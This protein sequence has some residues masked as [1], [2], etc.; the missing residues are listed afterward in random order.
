ML[1]LGS[2]LEAFTFRTIDSMNA[3]ADTSLH[4]EV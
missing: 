1:A 3:F 2:W 4:G